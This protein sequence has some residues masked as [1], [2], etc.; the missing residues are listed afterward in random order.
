MARL[1][2]ERP[3]RHDRA[4]PATG[5]PDE[6][7]LCRSRLADEGRTAYRPD[8]P[9]RALPRQL[10][11]ETPMNAHDTIHGRDLFVS[12]G[13]LLFGL[14]WQR[15]VARMLGPLH[16]EGGRNTIDDRLV[17]RWAA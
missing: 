9:V 13:S 8:I 10:E 14:E 17:R 1:L 11:R 15:P 12:A 4:I 16:P 6:T 2:W 5:S 7:G 3:R